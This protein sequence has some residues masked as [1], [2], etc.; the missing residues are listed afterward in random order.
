MSAIVGASGSFKTGV[1]IDIACHIAMGWPWRGRAVKQGA[2]VYAALEGGFGVVD[3]FRAWLKEHNVDDDVPVYILREPVD[4]AHGN[5]DARLLLERIG[6]LPDRPETLFL[7]TASRALAGAD[8]NSSRDVGMFVRNCDL[9]RLEAGLHLCALHHLGKDESRGARGHSLLKAAIDTELTVTRHGWAGAI[10]ITKQRDYPDGDRF[11]FAINPVDLDD[12]RTSYVVVESDPPSRR[13][14]TR[15]R[16]PKGLIVFRD[17]MTNA[18]NGHGQDHRVSGD[19]PIVKAVTVDQA[20]AE[21]R[22]LYLHSGDG[23]PQDARKKAF[24]RALQSARA[25][26]LIGGED[27]D[28]VSLIWLL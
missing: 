8:E 22:K 18:I 1:A 27:V 15:E 4:L 24:K 9:V 14:A 5:D 25:R 2:V 19:G 11:G 7:D 23:D 16:W 6:E 21:H 3:R 12:G 10:E 17:A 28:S 20:R 26:N 13:A